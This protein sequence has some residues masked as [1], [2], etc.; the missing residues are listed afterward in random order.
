MQSYRVSKSKDESSDSTPIMLSKTGDNYD[1]W[2][3]KL[4]LYF[5]SENGIIGAFLIR[6][7][8]GGP[9]DYIPR[10]PAHDAEHWTL[11][12]VANPDFTATDMRKLRMD[13]IQAQ[14]K[15]MRADVSI[16]HQWYATTMSTLYIDH[17]DLLARD[18]NW[19][20][21]ST[22]RLPLA[23]IELIQPVIVFGTSGLADTAAEDV[24]F[25]RWNKVTH[26]VP[27]QSVIDYVRKTKAVWDCLVAANHP[28][29]GNLASAIREVC[30]G[31]DQSRFR[32]WKVNTANRETPGAPDPYPATFDAIA[33]SVTSYIDP[34][35]I[36][37]Q[38]EVANQ[39]YIYKCDVCHKD[40]H[41]RSMCYTEHP[42]LAPD[43]WE[44][45]VTNTKSNKPSTDAK[46]NKP[47]TDAKSD[48]KATDP[49]KKTKKK[50]NGKVSAYS[51]D[52]D[53]ESSSAA[54]GLWGFTGYPVRVIY[55]VDVNVRDPRAV[56][57]DTYA[58]HS[59]AANAS[60]LRNMYAESY[61]VIGASGT[62]Q[63]THLGYLPGFDFRPAA[64][65]P[66]SKA[67]GLCVKDAHRYKNTIEPLV[68]WTI[69]IN[70]DFDLRFEWDD[71]S[72]H[73]CCLFD[74]AL[75]ANLDSAMT[76]KKPL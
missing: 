67:N 34:L 27:N 3:Q 47:Y 64:Y 68:C 52:I 55:A 20:V 76:S 46:S 41:D 66:Q 65:L 42:E 29:R 48:K 36:R 9:R 31:L 12:Q 38:R 7:P 70:E 35:Q 19:D 62:G 1:A 14:D 75:L 50:T 15:V 16:Y 6:P 26:Q 56:C 17:Q 39:R 21:V 74:D 25:T 69:H 33:Q 43:W 60:L 24:L 4:S 2:I 32:G 63:G 22:A 59:F 5:M 44:R 28:K 57:I 54:L 13:D 45:R 73:Y 30:H 11:I 53:H 49:K 18:A 23:L 51:V 10:Q 61:E 37:N 71:D 72:G 8:G 58:N 40:G